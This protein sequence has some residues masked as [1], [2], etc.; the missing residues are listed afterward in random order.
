MPKKPTAKTIARK[1]KKVSVKKLDAGRVLLKKM[2][3][4]GTSP[5]TYNLATPYSRRAHI[6]S[7]HS[8]VT[9]L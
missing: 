9:V 3:K 2:R 1:N 6:E 8:S 5:R 4:L 7:T